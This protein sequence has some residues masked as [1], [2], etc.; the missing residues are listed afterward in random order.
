MKEGPDIA[1]IAAL[2]GDPARANMLAA[3]MDGRALTASELAAEAGVTKQTAS[4][5][6]A[7]LAG[8]GLLAVEAQG[9]HRY[10]QLAG[11][12]VGEAIEALMGLAQARGGQRT[13]TGPKDPALRRARICY[14]HLAGEMGVALYGRL[15]KRRWLKLGDGEITLTSAGARA[16]EGFGVDIGELS[17]LRRPLCRA[18]LDWSERRHHLAGSLGEALLA[19]FI[20]RGWAQRER[21]T[22]VIAFNAKGERAL[23]DWLG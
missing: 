16:M 20:Q 3:L 8:G 4:S 5:H 2:I 12:E 15:S 6:L 17:T 18:C 21:G 1:R 14:G 23:A 9:R 22:R 11:E 19:R 13:R 10:F 7:R